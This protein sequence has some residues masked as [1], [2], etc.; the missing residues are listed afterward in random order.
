VPA[1]SALAK[2]TWAD[3][4][5]A[6]VS[7][8][9]LAFELE[10]KRSELAFHEALRHDTILVAER[11]GEIVGYV[12]FGDVNISELEPEPGDQELHRIYVATE[13]HGRGIGH[14]LM[15]AALSHPRLAAATRVFLQVWE[16]NRKAVALYESLGFR[17][18]GTTR[19]TIGAA[20]AEDLV[21][22]LRRERAL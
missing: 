5:G 3:A 2:R 9:E 7:A 13:L 17:T 11:A 18:V 4:F 1:I 14:A 16:E 12:Q 8:E 15:D 21:M 10:E 6:T 19:F 20:V 22:E